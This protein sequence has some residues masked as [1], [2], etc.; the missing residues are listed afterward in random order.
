[1]VGFNFDHFGGNGVGIGVNLNGGE[2]VLREHV[3][4]GVVGGTRIL[5]RLVS[6]IGDGFDKGRR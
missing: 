2:E 6:G 4:D 5:I 1:V 3:D